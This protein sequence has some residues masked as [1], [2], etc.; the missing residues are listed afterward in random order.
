MKVHIFSLAFLTLALAGTLAT[1]KAASA[2]NLL[3]FETTDGVVLQMY[4]QGTDEMEEPLPPY[5]SNLITLN[6]TK[7]TMPCLNLSFRELILLLSKPE[8]EDPLPFDLG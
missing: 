3:K 7:E 5:V 8:Q 2:E 1:D 6:Q 4:Q